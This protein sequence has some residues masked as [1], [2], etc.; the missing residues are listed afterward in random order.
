M[1]RPALALLAGL[2]LSPL[3]C[4]R[5]PPV[6]PDVPLE[7]IVQEDPIEEEAGDGRG[8]IGEDE[9]DTAR[10]VEPGPAETEVRTGKVPEQPE[11]S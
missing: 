8:K 9:P 7:P 4:R 11:A 1:P 2:L 3:A 6:P 10:I 5:S